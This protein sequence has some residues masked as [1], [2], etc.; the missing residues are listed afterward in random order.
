MDVQTRLREI[1]RAVQ[2]EFADNTQTH[3]PSKQHVTRRARRSGLVTTFNQ[4]QRETVRLFAAN[5]SSM[6]NFLQSQ[7][8]TNHDAAR[9]NKKKTNSFL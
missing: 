3:T 8:S 7:P 1:V 4:S 6:W 2:R 5:Y 9:P